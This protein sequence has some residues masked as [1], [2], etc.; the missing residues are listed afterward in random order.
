[1]KHIFA[2]LIP[3]ND[4]ERAKTFYSKSTLCRHD[5]SSKSLTSVLGCSQESVRFTLEGQDVSNPGS[6]IEAR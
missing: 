4:I 5:G 6:P 2:Y 3:A 1:V